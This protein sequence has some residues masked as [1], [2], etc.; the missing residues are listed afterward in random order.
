MNEIPIAFS[1]AYAGLVS[2]INNPLGLTVPAG[3]VSALVTAIEKM[4]YNS[5]QLPLP[6]AFEYLRQALRWDIV[7]KPLLE[8]CLTP[9][10]APDKGHYLTEAER[11]SR[12]KDAFLGQVVRDKDAFLEQVI[13]DKDAFYKQV[14]SNKD[15][16]IDRYHQFLP[17]RAYHWLKQLL[18]K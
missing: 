13:I 1:K 9:E 11:I 6:Q 2:N 10:F 16:E 12:D 15:A 14:I 4:I 7:V 3:D 5:G 17:I 18:G 8:F